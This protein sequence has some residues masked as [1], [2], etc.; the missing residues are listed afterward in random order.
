MSHPAKRNWANLPL[1]LLREI[2]NRLTIRD[3]R[4][5]RKV[6]A[7]WASVEFPFMPYLLLPSDDGQYHTLLS[8]ADHT[9]FPA[10]PLPALHGKWCVGSQ[11]NW[12][13]T[14]DKYQVSLLNVF[15]GE[16]IKL[17]SIFTHPRLDM[18]AFCGILQFY[19]TGKLRRLLPQ[20][21]FSPNPSPVDYTAVV[22]LDYPPVQFMY[23]RAGEDKWTNLEELKKAQ[24]VIYRDGRFLAVLESGETVAVDLDVDGRPSELIAG[25]SADFSSSIKY[26]VDSPGDLLQV[27]RY[28]GQ[29]PVGDGDMMMEIKTARI[30]VFR[31]NAGRDEWVPVE[32]LG[33]QSLFVGTC[34]SFS[35]EDQE[36]PGLKGNRVYFTDDCS[37]FLCSDKGREATWDVGVFSLEDGSIE[38]CL[39]PIPSPKPNC[40]RPPIWIILPN[41]LLDVSVDG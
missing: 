2:A 26:L 14:L 20:I 16:E 32:S 34:C 3:C 37:A 5:F 12:L 10:P 39:P 29:T 41:S 40:R 25:R 27:R 33:D 35:F 4:R 38:T 1:D 15:T 7:S 18:V 30:Q 9:T 28:F 17:P 24:E 21:V 19:M 36:I 22:L 13:A 11:D 8:A 31:W 6:C 23:T